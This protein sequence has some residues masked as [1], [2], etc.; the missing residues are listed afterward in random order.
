MN[1]EQTSFHSFP[2]IALIPSFLIV[3][4]QPNPRFLVMDYHYEISLNNNRYFPFIPRVPLSLRLF[5]KMLYSWLFYSFYHFVLI[6]LLILYLWFVRLVLYCW[7]FSS[8][9]FPFLIIIY[10]FGNLMLILYIILYLYYYSWINSSLSK[11][12]YLWFLNCSMC[13]SLFLYSFRLITN[14]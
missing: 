4:A 1:F 9:F 10:C 7:M 5:I 2:F 12:P 11:L 14:W 8:L 6:I 13:S 3:L